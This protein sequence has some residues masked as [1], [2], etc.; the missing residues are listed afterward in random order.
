MSIRLNFSFFKKLL[1]PLTIRQYKTS[2]KE[3][4]FVFGG[5]VLSMTGPKRKKINQTAIIFIESVLCNTKGSCDVNFLSQ[6]AGT[7]PIILK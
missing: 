5:G 4:P 7:L 1:I 2:I 6:K 3:S